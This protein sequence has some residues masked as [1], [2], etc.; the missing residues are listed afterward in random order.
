MWAPLFSPKATLQVRCTHDLSAGVLTILLNEREVLEAELTG[1]EQRRMGV[2]RRATGIYTGEARVPVGPQTI[3]VRVRSDDER[4][5]ASR[6]VQ[7]SFA[8]GETRSLVVTFDSRS[9]ALRV[10]LD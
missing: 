8:A 6:E 10:S 3:R 9:G 7:G 2:F 5:L 1:G 4:M